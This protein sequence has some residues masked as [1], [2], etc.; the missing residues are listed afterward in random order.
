MAAGPTGG[1]PTRRSGWPVLRTPRWM[2]AGGVVLVA[3]LTLAA[4]PHHPSTSQRVVDLRGVVQELNTDIE[5]CAGGVSESLTALRDIQSGT[6]HDI[7]TAVGI[8]TFGATNCSPANNMPMDDLVQY[9]PPESLASFHLE[10]TVNDLVT[11]GFPDAQR[12]Q[13]D[14]ATL[15]TAGTPSAIQAATA[16][17]HHDQSV[18]DA[19]RATIDGM[20][21]T[22]SKSLSADVKPPPLPS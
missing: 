20:I 6:S 15:L 8:A 18:L 22:A 10:Q 2:L 1:I 13:A 12:V 7:K 11:W 17:L 5:S 16:Q 3:G 4:I 9:Q 14:V 21:N 19:E